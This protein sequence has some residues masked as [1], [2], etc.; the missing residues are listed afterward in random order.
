AGRAEGAGPVLS[1]CGRARGPGAG[2]PRGRVAPGDRTAAPDGRGPDAPRRLAPAPAGVS[3][4]CS[5][6]DRSPSRRRTVRA[7][8]PAVPVPTPPPLAGGATT[9]RSSAG[10]RG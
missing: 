10:A 7:G 6:H 2:A 4:R 1:V 9:G 5:V 8:V 3:V